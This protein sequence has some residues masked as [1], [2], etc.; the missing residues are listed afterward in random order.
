MGA[1][2]SSPS[3]KSRVAV[4][5][6]GVTQ[7]A[8][9]CKVR[10]MFRRFDL[11]SDGHI[12]SSEMEALIRTLTNGAGLAPEDWPASKQ[13][14]PEVDAAFIVEALDKDKNGTI[15]EDEWVE[16]ILL[17]LSRSVKERAA[18]ASKAD[19]NMRLENF[20]G[21]I[22][23]VSPVDVDSTLA[24]AVTKEQ[25]EQQFNAFD[26]DKDGK[27]TLRELKGMLTELKLR[28]SIGTGTL[29]MDKED[30]Q[31][32][33]DALDQ[34]GN[35]S[36]EKDE[37]TAWV[38]RGLGRPMRERVAWANKSVRNRRLDHFLRAVSEA[39]LGDKRRSQ[40]RRHLRTLFKK[41]D[42]DTDGHIT[43]NEMVA[44]MTEVRLSVGIQTSDVVH[45]DADA[46]MIIMAMDADGNGAI[47]EDEFVNWMN[48]G[49]SIPMSKRK[50]FSE[51]SDFN[52]RT[53]GF[54]NAIEAYIKR[55]LMIEPKNQAN[56]RARLRKVFGVYDK[57]RDGQ[58]STEEAQSMVNAMLKVG[59]QSDDPIFAEAG[60]KMIRALDV[61][62][63]GSVDVEEF[64]S[65]VS[66]GVSR[67]A[68]ERN[69]FGKR[70]PVNLLLLQLLDSIVDECWNTKC[71][72]K[73]IEA[74]MSKVEADAAKKAAAAKATQAAKSSATRGA[75]GTA[76]DATVVM[77][78]DEFAID[79]VQ[80]M[81]FGGSFSSGITVASGG[82]GKKDPR[83]ALSALF[84][85]YDT[86][87][88]GALS[89]DAFKAMC[90]S[91]LT[92]AKCVSANAVK[93]FK[94]ANDAAVII[95][96]LDMDG[97]GMVEKDEFV[98]WISS[99][100][101]RSKESRAKFASK[102]RLNKQLETFLQAIE[103][104]TA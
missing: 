50:S 31:T 97:D 84:S 38:L 78:D 23:S 66:T 95:A 8:L 6:A 56:I 63:D 76:E 18:Y 60:A 44:M 79:E 74:E 24:S 68:E 75:A 12:S 14:A 102:N 32:L 45:C 10:A 69:S 3:K 70:G 62:G 35:G 4:E 20:L 28:T 22:E 30:A 15:E 82:T 73:E 55:I 27:I 7:Y 16:W 98:S 26:R 87:K 40:F 21:M 9:T 72:K 58:I 85:E 53:A 36:V 104:L 19:R 88:S 91:V 80:E 67:T 57:D 51:K 64:V 1:G 37:F 43:Q 81:S 59:P 17:G 54:L 103:E 83:I 49:L 41:F 42:L 2:A 29:Q 93:S 92:K 25:L 90:E 96:A 89:K 5:D 77:D 34:D 13:V 94:D 100:M 11:D 99:G 52:K 47:E 48:D 46:K 33:M 65:W 39:S 101:K 61:D 86:D 71:T